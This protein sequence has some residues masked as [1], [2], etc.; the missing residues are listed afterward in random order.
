MDELFTAIRG[1]GAFLNGKPIKASS[2][3]ELVKSLLAT[4]MGYLFRDVAAGAVIATEAGGLVLI[5]NSGKDFDISSQRVSSYESVPKD[6]FI[7]ALQ[8]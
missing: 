1:K 8:Q 7:E 3:N 2:Q 6:A 5:R 4:E